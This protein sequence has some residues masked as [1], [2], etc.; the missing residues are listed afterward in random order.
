[1]PDGP[2]RHK[3]VTQTP[4]TGARPPLQPIIR[5]DIRGWKT[6]GLTHG[7]AGWMH[8]GK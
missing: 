4:I 3:Q 2:K 8:W 6:P 7:Q 5:P 1:M